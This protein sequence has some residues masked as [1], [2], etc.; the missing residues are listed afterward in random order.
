MRGNWHKRRAAQTVDKL[1]RPGVLAVGPRASLHDA[2]E[3]MK[4]HRVGALAVM[5]GDQLT[6]IITERDLLRAAAY[7]VD[8]HETPISRYMTSNPATIEASRPCA[9][10]AARMIELRV[11]H[12]P[13]VRRARVVGV[14]SARDL[15]QQVESLEPRVGEPW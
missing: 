13:V 9:D 2:A 3:C 4:G 15:L 12:L 7:G 11:R 8:F 6:G 1:M 14:I 5:Q 10:A